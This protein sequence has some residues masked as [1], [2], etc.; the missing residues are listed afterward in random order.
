MNSELSYSNFGFFYTN[1]VVIM[2]MI[3]HPSLAS[4]CAAAKSFSKYAIISGDVTVGMTANYSGTATTN[5]FA[6]SSN[7]QV[8]MDS[9]AGVVIQPDGEGDTI[10]LVLE[11]VSYQYSSNI[12]VSEPEDLTNPFDPVSGNLTVIFSGTVNGN[13]IDE[14]IAINL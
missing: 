11:D 5:S 12:F 4:A 3:K 1:Y 2:K 14:T 13:T 9:P 6:S 7:F 8:N 10:T